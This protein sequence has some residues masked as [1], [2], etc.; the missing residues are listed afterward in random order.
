[1]FEATVTRVRVMLSKM[2]GEAVHRREQQGSV[3]VLNHNT[4]D[5]E[6][7]GTLL[8]AP[9]SPET[10]SGQGDAGEVDI[11]SSLFAFTRQ[12]DIRQNDRLVYEETKYEVESV[13]RRAHYQIAATKEV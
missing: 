2:G 6:N 4:G 5:Y 12:A 11:G 7:I 9:Y 13:T 1:M 8:C 10:N 3:D